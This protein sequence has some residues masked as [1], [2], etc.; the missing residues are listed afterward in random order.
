MKRRGGGAI[1]NITSCSGHYG[2]ASVGGSAYDASKG[3]LRQLT[4]SLAAEFGPHGI[5]VN[6]IAPGVIV[7]EG[8]GGKA[9]EESEGGRQEAARTPLRR[10]GY[11]EDVGSVAVFLASA[12]SA[13]VNGVSI[14]LDGGAMAVW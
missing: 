8:A 1:V 9:M 14:I 11:P 5:R 13:Y 12:D 4:A 7:T 6:A 10:L 2:G 3:G